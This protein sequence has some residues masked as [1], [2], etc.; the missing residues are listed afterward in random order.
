MRTSARVVLAA[1]ILIYATAAYAAVTVTV[2]GSSHTIP[3]TNEKGWGNNVTAWIQAISANTLQP[4]GGTFTLTADTNFGAT[5][6]LVSTYYKSRTSNIAT[7]GVLRLANT[8]TIGFRNNANGG[9]LLLGVDSSDRLTFN[10][11]PLIGSSSLTASRALVSDASGVVTASSVTST[12]LGYV[13][14]VTSALQTQLDAKATTA[15][16]SS[17]EA[18]TTSI[19][20]I[21]DTSALMTGSSTNTLTNKTFDADA[22]GNSISNIENA[23]IKAAAGID[24]SK[25]AAVT[26]SRALVSDGSG[27]VSPATTTATEIGYVNGVTSSLCGINQSCTLTNKTLTAPVVDVAS[28]TEQGSTPATPS[29]GTKKLYAKTDGKVYTLNS[30]GQEQQVGAGAGGSS[31]NYMADLYSGESVSGINRYADAAASSPV[32]GTGGSPNIT[33]AALNTSTPLRGT[34]SIRLS[35]DGSSRQGEGWSYDFTL[36]RADYEGGKPV[37][38]SFRYKTSSNYVNNDVR[39]F[40]YDRDAATLLN[41]VS[42]T[43][44]GSV[45]Y[46]ANTVLYTGQFYPTS[47]SDDYRLIFHISSTTSAAWDLDVIDTKVSPDQLAPGVIS[48]EWT[49]FT[50]TGLLSTNTTYIGKWRRVGD[51]MEVHIRAI[52]SGAANAV[53]ATVD[54]PSGYTIDTAKINTA[55]ANN[56]GNFGQAFGHDSGVGHIGNIIYV[57]SNTVTA[58]GDDATGGWS[59]TLPFTVG[60]GDYY[61]YHF[62][63]PIS[64]WVSSAALSTTETLLTVARARASGDAASASSGNP[65]IFPTRDYDA[66]AAYSVSTGLYTVPRTGYYKIHGYINSANTATTVKAY[67]SAVDTI[68]LG[69]TDSNGECTYSG[70]VYATAGSTISLRPGGTLDATAESTLHIEELPDFSIFSVYGQTEYSESK[71]SSSGTSWPITAGQF[72]DLTS[73]VLQPGEYDLTAM[74]ET[75]NNGSVTAGIVAVGISTTSGNSTTGLENG[76]NRALAYNVGTTGYQY[77][78]AVPNYRVVVTTPTTYYLKGYYA[79]TITNFQHTGYRL[80]ARRVK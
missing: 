80:S 57:D 12:E 15:A 1:L 8:D 17:H 62:T 58:M 77:S 46:S 35:K 4:S 14:G 16:L 29:A 13:S 53:A 3:Q 56:L 55:T 42:L 79:S 28:L 64:G 37:I 68:D 34:S 39:M 73:L 22:T 74:L 38:I 44:D 78:L 49:N 70:T 43:G 50:P 61:E 7:S 25:L 36:D 69:T 32:D 51:S 33:A 5:Y 2:N 48:T 71:T 63:V 27:F 52:F 41:V 54:L 31:K 26:A 9:N 21:A 75:N 47:T 20:G 65:I 45:A 11:N 6:G 30:S 72:G 67:V 59:N 18:D 10:G 66:F 23:D 19:H 76:V 40:V 60:S 24:V